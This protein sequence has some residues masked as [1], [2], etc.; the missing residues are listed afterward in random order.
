VQQK[1]EDMLKQNEKL[2]ADNA[3]LEKKLAYANG[4]LDQLKEDMEKDRENVRTLQV[5]MDKQC[6]EINKQLRQ[7][8]RL[9][10]L[11][12]HTKI[13]FCTH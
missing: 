6:N 2:K 12:L 5:N 4:K 3:E 10:F 1:T 9:R 7:L 11:F 13:S 8:V